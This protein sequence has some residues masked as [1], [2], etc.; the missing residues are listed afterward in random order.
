MTRFFARRRHYSAL[1]YALHFSVLRPARNG[2][3]GPQV[4]I[5]LLIV[6]LGIDIGRA[7]MPHRIMVTWPRAA[8]RCSMCVG[9]G[10]TTAADGACGPAICGCGACRC[11]QC[12][13]AARLR[14]S[15]AYAHMVEHRAIGARPRR[16]L[17][18]P[19]GT[20][21]RHSA[22]EALRREMIMRQTGVRRV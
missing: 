13:H 14:A 9:R 5:G 4:G 18:A 10:A 15:G 21:R 17:Q 8:S 16:V 20:D 12:R 1:W 6:W 3:W 11:A 2:A 19:A 7:G 22:Q